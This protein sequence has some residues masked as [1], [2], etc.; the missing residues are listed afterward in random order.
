MW[1]N[2]VFLMLLFSDM[3]I[4]LSVVFRRLKWFSNSAVHLSLQIS[5]LYCSTRAD[6]FTPFPPKFPWVLCLVRFVGNHVRDRKHTA[7]YTNCCPI[8]RQSMHFC[9]KT[10]Q[11]LANIFH[12]STFIRIHT[13]VNKNPTI[14]DSMQIFIYCKVTLHVSGVTP[15][16]IRSTKNCNRSLRY[17]S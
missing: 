6:K 16:I 17:R 13:N 10:V 11:N 4:Y 2:T 7:I 8:P 12:I 9:E 5:G 1:E 14:C 3:Y 15:P